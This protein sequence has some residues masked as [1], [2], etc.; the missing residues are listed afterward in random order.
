VQ[1]PEELDL[2]PELVVNNLRFSRLKA[3]M[4]EL[5]QMRELE[6]ILFQKELE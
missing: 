4:T 2:V 5:S 1:F 6:M 3:P